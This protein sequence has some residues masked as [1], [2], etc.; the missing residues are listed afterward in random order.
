MAKVVAIANQKGGVGK[1]TTAINLAAC[2]AMEDHR[3]LIIDSDPQGNATSGLGINRRRLQ[4]CLYNLLIE[5]IPPD[6]I[7]KRTG[8]QRLDI[9]PATI[10]LAGAE[11]ELAT[12]QE[13]ESFLKRSIAPIIDLY[14]YIFIDCPPSL[15]LLTINALTAANSVLVPLQCEYYA[16]EGLTQLMDTISI[17][18]RKLNPGLEV[19]GIVFTMFDGR[20]N[21]SIQVVE[22]VKRHFRKEIYRTIIPRNVRLSEAPSHG[23]PVISYNPR[24][25]GAE[26]YREL[27]MEVLNRD[28]KN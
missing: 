27:A 11:I 5:K 14:D 8:V 18:N 3:V 1:T 15:G 16:L 26:V 2:I 19:E 20:T 12:M 24:S 23:I 28:Q 6:R 21:L 17:V 7:I 22:E 13:R 10:Q 4:F 9:L 25:K